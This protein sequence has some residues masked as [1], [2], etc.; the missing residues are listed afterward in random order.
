F[1]A[2][3]GPHIVFAGGVAASAYAGKKY[4]DMNPADGGYHFGKDITY[5]FGTKPDILAVGAIFGV[6]GMLFTRVANGV[7]INV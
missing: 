4:P 5:A 3:T 2:I 6:V 1:G 7:F